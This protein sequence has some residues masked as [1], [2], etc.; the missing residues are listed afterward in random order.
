MCLYTIHLY[1]KQSSL[2]SGVGEDLAGLGNL[3]LEQPAHLGGVQGGVVQAQLHQHPAGLRHSQRLP[4]GDQG[5]GGE[6]S[7]RA[8]VQV[9]QGGQEGG[10]GRQQGR[11]PPGGRVGEHAPGRW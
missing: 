6:P 5:W 4:V 10:A 1:S 11:R 2:D 9:C 7:C 8:W 3:L